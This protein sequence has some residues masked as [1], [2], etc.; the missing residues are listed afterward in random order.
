MNF[1]AFDAVYSLYPVATFEHRDTLQVW[2]ARPLQD[3]TVKLKYTDRGFSWRCTLA[4]GTPLHVSPFYPSTGR[5][6]GDQYTWKLTLDTQGVDLRPQMNS[7]SLFQCDPVI[8]NGWSMER[9][10]EG[11]L[12]VYKP[13]R[14]S[15]FRYNYTTANCKLYMRLWHLM[16]EQ[17]LL[18][19]LLLRMGLLEKDKWPWYV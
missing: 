13:I 2:R 5:T 12:T 4:I 15:V 11:M 3:L 19:R 16:L 17:G 1:I 18:S 6:V 7:S 14:S 10:D 9:E 8:F